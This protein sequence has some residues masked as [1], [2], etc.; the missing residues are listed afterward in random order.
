[1]PLLGG[2]LVPVPRLRIVLPHSLAL[3]VHQAEVGLGAR[4]PLLGG[5]LVPVP[6]L[7]M[8]LPHSLALV[9]HHAEVELGARMPLLGGEL[10]PVQRLRI[11]LPHSLAQGVHQAEF[12]LGVRIPLPRAALRF[13]HTV[14][15]ICR[16]G[17]SRR[18][19]RRI[20]RECTARSKQ[21][22][23]QDRFLPSHTDESSLSK[24]AGS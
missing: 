13:R 12:E 11:V 14:S 16:A 22:A 3:V 17:L 23:S 10:K 15:P 19:A 7:R 6:R 21:H 8:V 24:L 18:L 2:E 1:M 20:K 4:M 9:V 5:E